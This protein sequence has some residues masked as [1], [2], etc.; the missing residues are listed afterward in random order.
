VYVCC[1]CIKA[2]WSDLVSVHLV[3]ADLHRANFQE[4]DLRRADLH[5][6]DLSEA[7]LDRVNL[8]EANLSGVDLFWAFLGGADLRGAD[9]HGADL[10]ETNLS[11]A[12]FVGTNLSEA[13]LTGCNVYGASAWDI[14]DE[15]A[16][17]SNLIITKEND[18]VITV[19]NLEVAQF[20]CL[21]LN[22]AKLPGVISTIGK[23]AV[24]ILG[25]FTPPER[26]E[27]LDAIKENLRKRDFLPI[28]F[29]F[30]KATARDV[31]ETIKV[32]AG[33]SLFVIADITHPKSTPLELQATVPDYMIPFV[34]IIQ[35][36]ENPFAM[37]E[38]LQ[39][40]FPWVMGIRI[41]E[42]KDHL[43]NYLEEGIIKPALKKSNELI[44]LKNE[45]LKIRNIDEFASLAGSYD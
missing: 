3:K 32:L 1:Q 6:A 37:F 36:G 14:Q 44:T 27:I 7:N 26:K 39:R 45:V 20:V 8:R 17:Q 4:A 43:I 12:I 23:K 33:M 11:S 21:L 13:N 2:V 28:V 24:L 25:R 15:G 40:K 5:D 30:E 38:D 41:Y 29:D 31:T 9:L 35:K 34:P 42:N 18:P 10:H 16:K 19:D 22:N